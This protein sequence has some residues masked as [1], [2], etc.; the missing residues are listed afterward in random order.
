MVTAHLSCDSVSWP[1]LYVVSQGSVR[2]SVSMLTI[3]TSMSMNCDDDGFAE[4][5]VVNV[6]RLV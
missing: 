5:C 1:Q 6:E 4:N 3:G 2:M